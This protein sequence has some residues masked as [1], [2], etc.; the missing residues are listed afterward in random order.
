MAD[1]IIAL[2]FLCDA[3]KQ[4]NP[5]PAQIIMDAI[6]RLKGAP[7]ASVY[8]IFASHIPHLDML[9]AVS[10]AFK[11][12]ILNSDFTVIGAKE[13]VA[14]SLGL[15]NNDLRNP[16]DFRSVTVAALVTDFNAFFAAADEYLQT[17]PRP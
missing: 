9:L 13:P 7:S 16:E 12:S 3:R 10:N 2:A 11:H 5:Y 17:W 8:G 1:E 4:G 15:R 6:G 14:Y